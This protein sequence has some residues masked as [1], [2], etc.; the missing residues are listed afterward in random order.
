[1]NGA[2]VPAQATIYRDSI[3]DY[4]VFDQSAYIQDT[5]TRG[6][7]TVMAGLRFDRQ[8]DRANSGTVPQTAIFGQTT[9]TGLVFNQ[10]P[11]VTFAGAESGVKFNDLAPRLGL[12]WDVKGDGHN[13]VK[14]NYARYASQLP[15]GDASS[16]YNPVAQATVRYP[17]TDLN[18]DRFVQPNEINISAAP[19]AVSAGYDYL[20]PAKLT[21]SGT[22]DPNLKNETTDEMILGFDKQFSN[23][24][25]L[26]IAGIYRH[27][28]N[29]RW[30]D[31]IGID[32][33]DY[34]PV[35]FTS[36]VGN[37]S[38]ACPKFS[39]CPTITYYQPTS[40]NLSNFPNYIFTNRPNLSRSYKGVEITGR[41]RAKGF[42]LN[43]SFTFSD[44][45][46]FYGKGS[47]QDPT[48][49]ANL[50][51]DQYAQETGGSGLGNVF[52]AARW[53]LR[54]TLA[55]SAPWGVGL[56]ANY[57]GRSGYPAPFSILSPTRANG[58]GTATIYLKGL[59]DDRLPTFHNLDLRADKG[60]KY[61]SAKVTFSFEVFNVLNADTVQSIRLT[62][63]A[64]NAE[65]ISSLVAPRVI[66]FGARLNW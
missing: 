59:G 6:K 3:T 28:D 44:A 65:T 63:N 9:Q 52:V 60:V 41:G 29:F 46:Q 21:T 53:L 26:G 38:P 5:F 34:S 37:T 31:T 42:T 50:D 66:R 18:N 58:A 33:S 14:A 16:T 47:F 8:W 56:A 30:N 55:Y 45:K 20:N 32:D 19:L 2:L 43:G 54:G 23:S 17:W 11:S 57:N 24:F 39:Q 13:V 7:L 62:E 27:Y 49:I 25:A 35:T 4:N 10:L 40:K 64:S 48:N 51:G 61:K 15:D 36:A 22:V 12:T 1:V